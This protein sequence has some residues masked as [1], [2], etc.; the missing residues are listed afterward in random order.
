MLIGVEKRFV[1][2]A[3]SKTA[4]TSIEAA[5]MR[6]AEIHRGGT[7]QRKHI[8]LREALR[9][10]DFLFGQPAYAPGTFFKFGVMRDPV[11]WIQSWYRFR[12][13]NEVNHAIPRT[14]SFAEFWAK[15]DWNRYFKTEDGRAKRHQRHH[16]TAWDGTVL[17]DYI[18][19]Y[20]ALGDHFGK[21]CDALGVDS[22][23]PRK[24]VSKGP[25]TPPEIDDALLA[26]MRDFY[27][28][29]YALFDRLDEINAAGLERLQATRP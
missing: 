10:Y 16:F 21:I 28:E 9:D 3:N 18:I 25:A 14:M 15:A 29:D 13:G 8:R 5:L 22:P 4:S 24:N 12:Q 26:E 27:A 11:D 2:V 6:H 17:A 19:P 1:F 7:P 23:L 20:H